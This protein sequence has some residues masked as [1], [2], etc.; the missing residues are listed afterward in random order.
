M[1]MEPFSYNMSLF[2]SEDYRESAGPQD[3]RIMEDDSEIVAMIKEL[4]YTRLRPA[5][6]EDGGG[7]EYRGF[8]AQ[9]LARVRL[10]G[11]CRVEDVIGARSL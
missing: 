9:Y 8:T 5:I 6:T 4:L 3:T 10:K 11:S 1:L 7:I 2:R